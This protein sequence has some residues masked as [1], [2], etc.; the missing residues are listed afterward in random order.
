MRARATPFGLFAGVTFVEVADKTSIRLCS[1]SEYQTKSRIDFEVATNLAAALARDLSLRGC[2]RLVPNESIVWDDAHLRYVE[3][4]V[5]EGGRHYVQARVEATPILRAV[6]AGAEGGATWEE[7]RDLVMNE[8]DVT[9]ADAAEFLLALV[10]SQILVPAFQPSVTGDVP[11]STWVSSLVDVVSEDPRIKTLQAAETELHLLDRARIGSR[12]EG[13]KA[14]ADLVMATGF[15]VKANQIV[16]VDMSKPA[17]VATLG[18]GVCDEVLRGVAL[19]HKLTQ[20]LAPS[21]L[22]RF[23]ERFVDRFGEREIPL[24]RALDPEFGIGFILDEGRGC[25]E[26]LLANLPLGRRFSQSVVWGPHQSWLL[27]RLANCLQKQQLELKVGEEE[28]SAIP[29]PTAPPLPDAFAVVAVVAARSVDAVNRGEFSVLLQGASGPSGARLLGRFCHLD[30]RLEE[31]VRAHLRAEEEHNPDAIFAE[32]V[33]LPEGRIGNVLQRPV[34]RKYEIV[35][36]GRSG[37]LPDRQIPVNDL[38]VSVQG[39]RICLRSK[40]L[41]KEIIPRLTT[42]HNY[43]SPRNLPLYQFLCMLQTQGVAGNLRWDWGPLEVAS[44]LPRVRCGRIVFARARWRVKKDEVAPFKKLE[45]KARFDAVN[46]WRTAKRMPRFVYLVEGD[47]ELLIDFEEPLAVEVFCEEV[48]KKPVTFVAEMFPSPEELWVE[49]PEGK[50]VHELV[51]PFVRTGPGKPRESL[52]V[53]EDL[54]GQV[55]RSFPP[56]SEWLYAKLYCGEATADRLLVETV[57]PLASQCLASGAAESWFFIRYG[58]PDWHL[59]V[60]FFGQ[61]E[62]LHSQVLPALQAAA[63]R[64]LDRGRCWKFQL[65]TY[66]REVER[67]GGDAG[68]LAAERMFFADSEACCRLLPLLLG[69]E[70][71]EDRWRVALLAIH[72]LLDDLGFELEQRCQLLRSLRD[73]FQQEF[74]WNEQVK[75]R[76]AKRFRRERAGLERILCADIGE[77]PYPQVRE[78]LAQRGVLW[79]PAVA[80]F[81]RLHAAHALTR[82]LAEIAGSLIHMHVNR[83]LRAEHRAQEA[84]LYHFLYELYVSLRARGKQAPSA[85]PAPWSSS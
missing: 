20:A 78:I 77:E 18:R 29:T 57:A 59:R 69:D 79:R 61:P 41:G 47:N 46:T 19:L 66:E 71:A 12:I 44:F 40:R 15:D 22:E 76:V 72:A 67:Y 9:T 28:I 30:R 26:T 7:L 10:E 58:D 36:L 39:A 14:V 49:G 3:S 32:I 54:V 11:V 56:G 52:V 2:G 16:Q 64:E 38:L 5:G 35:Y 43:G 53:R 65:D 4:R 83:L 42:A 85:A 48:A 63:Q 45:P 62:K 75:E 84:V 50:F 17:S 31:A 21:A 80:E 33:H 82:P 24:A 8:A 1:R 60:R 51:I 81:M 55:R 27:E 6:I 23:R 13:Y 25:A 74:D 70:R 37:T 34:L 68:V 73:G